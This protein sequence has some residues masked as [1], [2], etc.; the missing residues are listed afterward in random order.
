MKYIFGIVLFFCMVACQSS[1]DN[2]ELTE[3]TKEFVY[4][5]MDKEQ[6][7]FTSWRADEII[8]ES[9]IDDSLYYL[10]IFANN[11]WSYDFCTDNYL[12]QTTF[13]NYPVKIYGDENELFFLVNKKIKR[14]KPCD[15]DYA[16]FDPVVWYICLNKDTT[17]CIQETLRSNPDED[18]SII[19]S[20]VDK[21][22]G[23][24]KQQ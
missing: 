16:E 15:P 24:S 7:T 14:K 12:G 9:F 4:S 10:H 18:I 23:D 1:V 8:M 6:S 21:C 11:S 2:I 19:Q 22:F 20:L 13:M 3:F 5:Y 17:L